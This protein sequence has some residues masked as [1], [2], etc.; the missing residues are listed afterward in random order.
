MYRPYR[1]R[2]RL[3]QFGFHWIDSLV[4]ILP[5]LTQLVASLSLRI[6]DRSTQDYHRMILNGAEWSWMNPNR[7]QCMLPRLGR[8]L[9]NPKIDDTKSG[10]SRFLSKYSILTLH[11]QSN[12]KS[13]L[14][15]SVRLW[16]NSL[17]KRESLSHG[18]FVVRNR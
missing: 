6:N 18:S 14:V 9:E 7:F 2:F 3:E 1:G 10:K 17:W 11:L 12:S 8:F 4:D 5:G 16:R 15:L 13:G